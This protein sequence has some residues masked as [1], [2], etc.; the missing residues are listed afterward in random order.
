MNLSG[1][2]IEAK[3]KVYEVDGNEKGCGVSGPVL[4][5]RTH[6]NV[7]TLVEIEIGGKRYTVGAADLV[8]A[9]NRCSHF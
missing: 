4:T 5:V 9:V 2:K 7:D 6:W 1:L 3:A 8:K